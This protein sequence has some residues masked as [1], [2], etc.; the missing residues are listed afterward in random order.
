MGRWRT[1]AELVVERCQQIAKFSEEPGRI[2]RT[3]L[4]PPM[5]DVHRLMRTWCEGAGASVAIDAAGNFRARSGTGRVRLVIGSHLDT[6]PNAGAF[7]GILGVMIGVALLDA[8]VYRPLSFG[9]EVI[10]FS[11]EEGVR[12]GTPFIGSRAVIGDLDPDLVA[13]IEPAI[14]E[15]G[16]DPAELD[17]ARLSSDTAE[18]LEF[19]IEQGP[20]L[21]HADLSLGV[22]T[23]I[24]GQSR[25]MFHFEGKAS[26]AGTTPMSL[27]RDA[28]SGAAEWILSVERLANRVE[29]LVATVGQ[30]ETP[31]GAGN[32][33][34]GEAR[35]SLDV[36][37]CE[38]KLRLSAVEE[39]ITN[40]E[41][42]AKR[43]GL[44]LEYHRLL[45]Q[46]A[47]ELDQ[48]MSTMLEASAKR[49][50]YP[51]ARLVS[52]AGHDAM[53]MARRFPSAL[54][55]LRSPGGISHHPDECVRVDDVEA[56]IATGA[57]F[58]ENLELQYV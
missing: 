37:H 6:V 20:V 9:V 13:R 19:H 48:R 54:L 16:G 32:V 33:V 49:A 52:G 7:D 15:F 55:F 26:H 10:G 3:Y 43:R 40:A 27:R 29:R 23:A 46:A 21:E 53:I 18:Y 51:V 44:L 25:L 30:L 56:A 38:D 39:M 5:H 50:G 12:F 31:S 11:E 34:P 24:A 58:L 2:T 22:A 36:R 42:I 41:E 17:G 57:E 47:V 35:A 1:A 28:L 4:S 45:N 8:M 14:R